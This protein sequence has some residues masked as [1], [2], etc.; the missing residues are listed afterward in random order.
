MVVAVEL[1]PAKFAVVAA[2]A[3][4]QP[5]TPLA[6]K[7]RRPWNGVRR[8]AAVPSDPVLRPGVRTRKADQIRDHRRA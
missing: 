3:L 8:L 7:Y 2:A 6:A 1:L 5:E 4:A